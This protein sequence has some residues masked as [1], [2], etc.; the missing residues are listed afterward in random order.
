MPFLF[1]LLLLV[2][3]ILGT[4]KHEQPKEGSESIVNAI[5]I[6]MKHKGI[7]PQQAVD[8]LL[9]ELATS[10]TVFEEA[11]GILEQSAGKEGQEL[12]KT[13]CDACRCMVTGSI[14]F[15]WALLVFANRSASA[16]TFWQIR[17]LPLQTGGLLE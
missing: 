16:N 12:M 5:P 10:V 8:D 13:Y 2:P 1:L 15:T 3:D 9:A 14:Q 17:I 4:D 7:S 11:A 6:L